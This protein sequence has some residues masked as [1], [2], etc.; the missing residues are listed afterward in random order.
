MIEHE[1]KYLSHPVVLHDL[2]VNIPRKLPNI[3]ILQCISCA[4]RAKFQVV[5]DTRLWLRA[6]LA[7]ATQDMSTLILV[8]CEAAETHI[9]VLM[10]G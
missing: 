1:R 3:F 2:I 6:Q 7:Q 8:C 5:L 9:D 4:S 10:A